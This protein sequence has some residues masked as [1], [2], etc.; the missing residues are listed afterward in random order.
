MA[1]QIIR[2]RK[3]IA[4]AD[5][6]ENKTVW[7]GQTPPRFETKLEECRALLAAFEAASQSQ[8]TD[9]TGIALDK[10]KEE[11]DLEQAA[12][13]YGGL[14]AAYA[15][16]A[17]NQAL[18]TKHDKPGSAWH[19]MRDAA[20]I[21]A[22]RELQADMAATVAGPDA[23]LAAQYGIDAAAVAALTKEADDYDACLVAP[24]DS[25][26][27]RAQLTLNLPEM[28]RNMTAHFEILERI[29]RAFRGTAAGEAFFQAFTAAGS[30]PDLGHGP[31]TGTGGGGNPT[32]GSSSLA[33]VSS[34]SGVVTPSSSSIFVSSSSSLPPSSTSSLFPSSSFP[35][36]S[37]SSL[38]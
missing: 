27:A 36:P 23:A 15:L 6:P 20:L 17:G 32:P 1:N 8:S 4:C 7:E 31:G 26:E 18:A 3:Q 5:R 2:R 13:N 33:P 22:A 10:L 9:R 28:A 25:I 12:Y 37:S 30:V 35:I 24:I 16:E 19:Q 11:R 21:Q 14:L 29:A 34:S 38:P